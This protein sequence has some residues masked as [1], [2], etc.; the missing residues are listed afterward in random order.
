MDQVI[1]KVGNLYTHVNFSEKTPNFIRNQVVSLLKNKL[2]ARPEGFQ[3]SPKFRNRMWDGWI[4]LYKNGKFPTGLLE[5]AIEILELN[6]E[7]LE[8]EII[9]DSLQKFSEI[10]T[11]DKDDLSRITLRD[12]QIEAI[13]RLLEA[14]RGVAWM[15]TNA[16]KTAVI[17]SL[18]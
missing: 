10:D 9:I 18:C 7:T 15:A 6:K 17:A 3:F 12:Y 5:D 4:R 14:G 1:L 2:R 11:I 16:G 8:F 13:Q